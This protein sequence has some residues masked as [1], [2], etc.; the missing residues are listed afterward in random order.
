[1]NP[2][3]GPP[4]APEIHLKQRLAVAF[5]LSCLGILSGCPKNKSKAINT[6][7]N[8]SHSLTAHPE[9]LVPAGSFDMGSADGEADEKPVH[10]VQVKSFYLDK[11]EVT[12][13]QYR[14]FLTAVQNGATVP[15]HEDCPKAKDQRP[16]PPKINEIT[17]KFPSDYFSNSK[18][19]KHPVVGIDW[20]DAYSYAAWA[21]RR[22]PSEAEWEYAAR[23][24][25]NRRFPWGSDSPM[26]PKARANYYTPR[27]LQRGRRNQDRF[28]KFRPATILDHVDGFPFIAPVGS[29]P[30]GEARC[31]ALDMAGNVWEW[32]G[33]QYYP[34][35][36]K[37]PESTQILRVLRGG[38]W[39]SPS[40]F[41][42][43]A[44]NRVSCKALVRRCSIGF[45]TAR[46]L[47]ADEK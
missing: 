45:R 46:N 22:L 9:V 47:K 2:K 12:N 27:P 28:D 31:G 16:S 19:D 18:Y 30:H 41:L 37:I 8:H 1:V 10:R 26:K 39:D 38:A 14:T 24:V 29:F 40:S 6:A 15:L 35:G 42:F 25:E 11:F 4:R 17:Y 43:R 13:G 3:A 34:Y 21:G 20:Y 44:S 36:K 5:T 33:S 23:S 32:T 7:N